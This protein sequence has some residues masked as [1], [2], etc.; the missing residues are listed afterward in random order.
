[1]SKKTETNPAAEPK[2][3][4]LEDLTKVVGGVDDG[5]SEHRRSN[6]GRHEYTT[7]RSA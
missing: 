6:D 4:T 5:N 2:E 1:M 3:L 7:P